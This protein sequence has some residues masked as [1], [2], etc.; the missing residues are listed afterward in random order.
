MSFKI[1]DKIRSQKRKYEINLLSKICHKAIKEILLKKIK[2]GFENKVFATF[3]YKR[4]LFENKNPTLSPVTNNHFLAR[5]TAKYYFKNLR[6]KN[7]LS[8]ANNSIT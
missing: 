8:N 7:P 4:F 2:K 3:K 1:S 5:N 6:K